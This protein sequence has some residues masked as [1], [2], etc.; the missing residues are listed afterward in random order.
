M[1]R[2]GFWSRTHFS[3]TRTGLILVAETRPLNRSLGY[4]GSVRICQIF[5]ITHWSSQSISCSSPISSLFWNKKLFNASGLNRR[6]LSLFSAHS[7][8]VCDIEVRCKLT[9]DASEIFL[10]SQTK[11]LRV[12]KDQTSGVQSYSSTHLTGARRNGEIPEPSRPWSV[13]VPT[14]YCTREYRSLNYVSFGNVQWQ[15]MGYHS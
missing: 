15:G 9:G 12:R 6:A 2:S 7:N 4:L 10:C 14:P 13:E 11:Y 1:P 5:G 8:V 3:M